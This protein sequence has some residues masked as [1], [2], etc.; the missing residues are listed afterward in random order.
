ME[1]FLHNFLITNII[2]REIIAPHRDIKNPIWKILPIKIEEIITLKI[3]T[4]KLGKKPNIYKQIIITMFVKP[5]FTPGIPIDGIKDSRI[6]TIIARA[7][8]TDKYA[9]FR[10]SN[11]LI[12]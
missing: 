3:L 1:N 7:V 8:N 11:F 12:K 4:I 10:I 5:N 9:I 2:M 6:E